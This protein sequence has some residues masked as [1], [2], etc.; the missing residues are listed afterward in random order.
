M[1][2]LAEAQ[3]EKRS[4]FA[5]VPQMGDL[6]KPKSFMQLSGRILL[7]SWVWLEIVFMDFYPIMF[8]QALLFEAVR[9]YLKYSVH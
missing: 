4:L 8:Y 9:F 3:E 6:N 1:L 5:G 7:V 2:I